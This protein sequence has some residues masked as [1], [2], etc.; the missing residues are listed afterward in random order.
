MIFKKDAFKIIQKGT[1]K[2]LLSYLRLHPEAIEARGKDNRTPVLEATYQNKPEHLRVLVSLNANLDAQ[3]NS[4]NTSLCIGAHWGHDECVRIL[5]AGGADKT[6]PG[7]NDILP[8]DR[9]DKKA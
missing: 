4:N 1:A 2:E 7:W 5:L 3:S 6:I 8:I 9:T